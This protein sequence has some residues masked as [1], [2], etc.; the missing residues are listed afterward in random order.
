ME[1]SHYT[2]LASGQMVLV[3]DYEE[4]IA[5]S[6]ENLDRGSMAVFDLGFGAFDE[7][8]TLEVQNG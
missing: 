4:R 3:T 1:I 6:I 8:E 2:K 5:G 7:I